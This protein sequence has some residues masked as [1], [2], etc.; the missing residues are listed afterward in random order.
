MSRRRC[1]LWPEYRNRSN[2]NAFY[3]ENVWAKKVFSELNAKLGF[4][5]PKSSIAKHLSEKIVKLKTIRG[6]DLKDDILNESVAN[7]N[8]ERNILFFQVES[9]ASF[10]KLQRTNNI[11]AE[12]KYLEKLI[13]INFCLE[14]DFHNP[15]DLNDETLTTTIQFTKVNHFWKFISE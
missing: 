15:V 14:D 2:S 12:N 3:F 11:S 7:S 9:F 1:I 13:T 5:K 6:A 10:Q 8:R 4:A